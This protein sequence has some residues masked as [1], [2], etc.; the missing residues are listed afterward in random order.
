M[1]VGAL[2]GDPAWTD[3]RAMLGVGGRALAAVALLAQAA[4]WLWLSHVLSPAEPL[5]PGV[6]LALLVAG[7]L[8]AAGLLALAAV[9]LERREFAAP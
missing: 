8:L 6:L 7:G 1:C 3:P 2:L 5:A 9:T 4:V